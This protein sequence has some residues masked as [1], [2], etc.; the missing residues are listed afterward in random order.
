[1]CK[2]YFCSKKRLTRVNQSVILESEVDT[3]QLCGFCS[4][5]AEQL[6]EGTD[7]VIKDVI[8]ACRNPEADIAFESTAPMER[9]MS[10]S[11][12]IG[13][14]QQAGTYVDLTP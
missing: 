9:W 7:G 4:A 1:M 8:A 11:E 3:S 13:E 6:E 14:Y 5:G 2:V 12:L 10:E